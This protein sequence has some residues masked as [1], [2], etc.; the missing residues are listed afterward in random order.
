LIDV[1]E[2]DVAPEV[3]AL[4]SR[5]LAYADAL[6]TRMAERIRAETPGHDEAQGLTFDELAA[7]CSQNL[8]Y[9][10]GIL[11][12]DS[13]PPGPD[14]PP[15]TGAAQVEQGVPYDAVLQASRVVG[16]YIWALLVE[17]AAQDDHEVLLLAAAD[18][19]S[20]IDGL[21]DQVTDSYRQAL[22]DQTRRD[23]VRTVL[24]GALLD[25]DETA[26]QIAEAARL[27]DFEGAND[28][29]AVSAESTEP[30][31]EGLPGVEAALRRSDVAS[32][33]H[34]DSHH[35]DGLVALPIG[36]GIFDLAAALQDLAVTRVGLS[37]PFATLD[38]AT[39]GRMQARAACAAASAG[40][41]EVVRYDEQPLGVLLAGGP[42][43]AR[44]MV[45]AVLGGLFDMRS[46]DRAVLLKTARTWL[47]AGGSNAATA[48]SLHVHKNTVRYRIRML[49][50]V[51]GRDL[52]RPADAAELFVA[53]ESVRILGLD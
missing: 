16:R 50:D 44:A 7:S 5:L 12:G 33:W 46:D 40:S 27:L 48:R 31:V 19:W 35:Q 53:L 15:A 28:F 3:R 21:S 20:V 42:E 9:V 2:T 45:D 49:E 13:A 51:T 37:R 47:A 29:V 10:L 18:I 4:S 17:E 25:G 38:H 11:A 26:E 24:V 30:G 14:S 6:A 39:E 41:A 1:G 34:L 8:Q 52:T 36:F 22:A 32:A 23:T 43:H